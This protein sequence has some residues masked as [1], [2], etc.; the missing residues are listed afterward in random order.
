MRVPKQGGA[1]MTPWCRVCGSRHELGRRCPGEC[2]LTGAEFMGF[3]VNVE[4]PLGVRAFGVLLGEAGRRWRARIIT[5]PNV[6]W[7]IPGGGGTMKFIGISSED[8]ERQ[9]VVYIREHCAMKGYTM[10]DQLELL[11]AVERR[12]LRPGEEDGAERYSR[13]LPVRYGLSKP[14]LFGRTGNLSETGLF[15]HTKIPIPEG[16]NAGLVL[17][18]EHAKLPLRGS[19]VWSRQAPG[20][21]RPPGMG[22]RLTKPPELYVSYIHALS[23]SE[24]AAGLLGE[25]VT[26]PVVGSGVRPVSRHRR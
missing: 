3:K 26:E 23:V 4:T 22:L 12:A 9:A 15:V 13:I 25:E 16:S 1:S 8:A 21:S 20:P 2:E 5:S 18:L 10:R 7:M 11:E 24:D 14:T 6:L 19:V 17:E